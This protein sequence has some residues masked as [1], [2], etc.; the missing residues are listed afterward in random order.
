ME[1]SR[2]RWNSAGADCRILRGLVRQPGSTDPPIANGSLSPRRINVRRDRQDAVT[3]SEVGE[4]PGK[5]VSI[6]GLP[7]TSVVISASVAR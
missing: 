2:R 3:P 7:S 5:T 1:T 4:Y 6:A